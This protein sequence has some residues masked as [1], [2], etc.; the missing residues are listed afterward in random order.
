M[1]S[2]AFPTE[3]EDEVASYI[4]ETAHEY[5]TTTKRPR[6][7]GWLDGVVLK[8]SANIN[9]LTGIALMLLDVLS[10]IDYLYV[11]TAY[12]LDGKVIHTIPSRVSDFERCKPIYEKLP[13]WEEDVTNIKNMKIY[14]K[15]LRSILSLLKNN[16]YKRCHHFG[17]SRYQPNNC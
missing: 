15:M 1:G 5:G 3:F 17:R 7:I 9:G 11:C 10:G 13:G 12:Q 6:R 8:Y 4:R 2:G 14:L 16:W